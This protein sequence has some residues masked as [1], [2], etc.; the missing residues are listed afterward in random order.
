M[1][2][3]E[4]TNFNSNNSYITQF[5]R[6]RKM[7]CQVC[8]VKL[9]KEV[10]AGCCGMILCK[11]CLHGDD[12]PCYVKSHEEYVKDDREN[13]IPVTTSF[14]IAVI[15]QAAYE[16]VKTSRLLPNLQAKLDLLLNGLMISAN[17]P[18]AYSIISTEYNKNIKKQQKSLPKINALP[19]L[20]SAPPI[21]S[22][23]L[24]APPPLVRSEY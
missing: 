5:I 18:E 2:K 17:I 11:C 16:M 4:Y 23:Q 20:D 19:Q 6:S 1:F 24:P 12:H 9:S 7:S 15:R 21:N 3:I 14:T 8:D 22:S 13:N 10:A